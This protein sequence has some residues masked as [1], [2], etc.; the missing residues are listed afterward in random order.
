LLVRPAE[1]GDLPEIAAIYAHH[2]RTGLASFEETAPDLAEM[3]RRFRDIRGKAFPY[4]VAATPEGGVLGYAYASRYHPRSAYRFTA[5]DSVYVAPERLGRGIGKALL[6]ALIADCE[7]MGLRQMVAL[8][9]DSGNAG[10]IGL[11][12]ALGFA[13]AGH[14][15]AVGFKFGR[16]VDVVLMQ[17]ALGPGD[18]ALPH[19]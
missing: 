16:W 11:H 15:K 4:L 5:E 17:R 18:S 12:K 2:V 19:G 7:R 10:S 3:T 8:I 6:A 9:G 1:E 14:L 13:P